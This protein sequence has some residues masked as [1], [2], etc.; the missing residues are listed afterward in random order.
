[1]KMMI[2]KQF[3]SPALSFYDSKDRWTYAACCICCGFL[4]VHKYRYGDATISDVS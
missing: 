2:S 4:H 3:L 1:M